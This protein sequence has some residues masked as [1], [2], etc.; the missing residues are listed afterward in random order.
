M[1]VQNG[2]STSSLGPYQSIA[3]VLSLIPFTIAAFAYLFIYKRLSLRQII[4]SLGLSASKLTLWNVLIGGILVLAIIFVEFMVGLA[5]AATNT[6]INTNVSLILAGAPSWF[7]FFIAVIEP[8]N[9]EIMFRGL[10]VPRF[11]VLMSA[12]I[13]SIGHTSYNSTFGVEVIASL[14]FGLLAGYAFKRTKSL[15]PSII[16]HIVI[17]ALAVIGFISGA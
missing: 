7:L 10:I 9:E 8:I 13:F 16:A 15:Y 17:N 2:F 11:G 12:I 3:E 1:L 5:G 4:D 14:L 6:Q